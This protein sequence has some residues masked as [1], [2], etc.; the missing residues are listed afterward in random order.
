M[1][2]NMAVLQSVQMLTFYVLILGL[3]CDT[4]VCRDSQKCRSYSWYKRNNKIMASY[5]EY[6]V[7]VDNGF[8]AL[9]SECSEAG[10]INSD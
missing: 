6:N 7:Q 5:M 1:L 2:Y 8:R 3:I 4:Y 10:F 9:E